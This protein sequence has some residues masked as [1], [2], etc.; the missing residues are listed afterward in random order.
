[1][2]A[3]QLRRSADRRG[4]GD[5]HRRRVLERDP[6]A[7]VDRLRLGEQERVPLARGLRRLEPLEARGAGPRRVGDPRRGRRPRAA[8]PRAPHPGSDRPLPPRN[9]RATRDR[10]RSRSRPTGRRDPGCPA[11]ACPPR[12]ESSRSAASRSPRGSSA[13]SGR[14]GRARRAAPAPARGWRGNGRRAGGS[15]GSSGV[16]ATER[17]AEARAA[18]R[19][20]NKTAR[21]RSGA[22]RRFE[23]RQQPEGNLTAWGRRPAWPWSSSCLVRGLLVGLLLGGRRVRLRGVGGLRGGGGGRSGLR[24][25]GRL[26]S[27]SRGLLSQSH[28]R[29]SG[30]E[31][32]SEELL[33]DYS[34]PFRR[35]A[36]LHRATVGNATR[37]QMNPT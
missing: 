16:I 3:T 25:L 31:R 19:G 23:I 37:V 33:H 34:S 20:P 32:Q 8:S 27:R 1:M 12:A 22:P 36:H 26:G 2:T 11:A 6:A 28:D 29:E 24:G 21:R 18:G 17:L 35:D 5:A 30:N 13:R 10:L 14:P 15:A 7:R 9:G 4:V